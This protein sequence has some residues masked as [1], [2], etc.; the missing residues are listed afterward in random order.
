MLKVIDFM[1][2]KTL[3]ILS[4][5]LVAIVATVVFGLVFL[6][7]AVN[8]AQLPLFG[9]VGAPDGEVVY[10]YEAPNINS[11]RVGELGYFYHGLYSDQL[12]RDLGDWLEIDGGYV[13]ADQADVQTWYGGKGEYIIVAAQP[14]TYIYAEGYD[15]DLDDVLITESGMYVVQG[16]VIADEV[17]IVGEYYLL[18]TAHDYLYVHRSDVQVLTRKEFRKL[19]LKSLF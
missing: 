1:K 7:K 12:I 5:I 19:I 10:I 16:T 14:R 18:M 15:P 3:L 6:N 2:N 11:K 8:N 17:Q 13:L 9:F 4:A